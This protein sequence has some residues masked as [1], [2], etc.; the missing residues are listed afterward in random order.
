MRVASGADLGAEY[1]ANWPTS[2]KKSRRAQ[3]TEMQQA[4][5]V[6]LLVLAQSFQHIMADKTASTE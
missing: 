5:Q 6:E 4:T 2:G 3:W 1:P